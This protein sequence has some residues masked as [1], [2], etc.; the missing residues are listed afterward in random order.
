MNLLQVY[1]FFHPVHHSWRYKNYFHFHSL[2]IS[3]FQSWKEFTEHLYTFATYHVVS[4]F[5]TLFHSNP[6]FVLLNCRRPRSHSRDLEIEE[7]VDPIDGE[8][9]STWVRGKISPG[10]SECRENEESN[11]RDRDNKVQVDDSVHWNK[12]VTFFLICEEGKD[13]VT[14]YEMK[15][16]EGGKVRRKG[17]QWNFIGIYTCIIFSWSSIT[18]VQQEEVCCG[19]IERRRKWKRTKFM[20][21]N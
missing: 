1:Y 2:L 3:S 5:S 14:E 18:S 11:T 19:H 6:R 17:K 16:K 10:W 12:S 21:H 20:D 15:W 13:A 8:N 7:I 4:P 9:H